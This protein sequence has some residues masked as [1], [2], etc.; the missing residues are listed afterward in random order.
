MTNAE[1]IEILNSRRLKLMDNALK[2]RDEKD[3]LTRRLERLKINLDEI[4]AEEATL[5]SII[6]DQLD[7]KKMQVSVHV[8]EE[9]TPTRSDRLML[10]IQLDGINSPIFKMLSAYETELLA[11][12][13]KTSDKLTL[14]NRIY[15]YA[16][17]HVEVFSKLNENGDFQLNI[18]KSLEDYLE[19][20]TV[21]PRINRHIF[22]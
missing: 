3:R 11:K 6:I 18:E 20:F 14:Q 19:D 12:A 16:K 1:K 10:M 17:N 8:V 22:F 7:F 4:E 9:F 5:E 2:M 13:K 15:N 21:E